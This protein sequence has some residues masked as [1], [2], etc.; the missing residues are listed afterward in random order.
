MRSDV[1]NVK[2]K[3]QSLLTEMTKQDSERDALAE[4]ASTYTVRLGML[5]GK[6]IS[7]IVAEK[8]LFIGKA[9]RVL[10]HESTLPEDRIPPQEME[11]MTSA[12][13]KLETIAPFRPQLF[14]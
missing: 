2:E 3:Y 13:V 8:I 4:W 1:S 9:V 7:A 5:P 6:F 10:L 11:E 14:A 12:L